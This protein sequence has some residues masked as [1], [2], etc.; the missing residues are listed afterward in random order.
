MRKDEER[1]GKEAKQRD[2]KLRVE[3]EQHETDWG[4]KLSEYKKS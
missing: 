1:D 4:R 2:F 3:A